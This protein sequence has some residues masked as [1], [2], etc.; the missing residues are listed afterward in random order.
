MLKLIWLKEIKDLLRDRK[1]LWFVLLMPTLIMP[2][3]MGGALYLT[4]SGI[5]DKQNETLDFQLVAPPAWRDTLGTLL[6]GHEGLRWQ[7]ELSLE[8]EAQWREAIE[9]ERLHFVLQVP[10]GFDPDQ[11]HPSQWQLYYNQ[12]EDFGQ[13]DRIHKALS[14]LYEQWREEHRQR[15]GLTESQSQML[16]E[17]VSLTMVGTA[18]EREAIGERIG[19][20]LPYLLL[21]L[22]LIGAMMPALDVAAG[23]KERGTLETL[24]MAPVPRWQLVL[25]KFAVIGC[26]SMLVATLS[27]LCGV[28]WLLLAGQVFAVSFLVTAATTLGAFD[29]FLI[30]LLILPIAFAMSAMLLALSVYARSYKEAQNYMSPVS[31]LIFLPAM[32]GMVPGM[33]LKGGWLWAPIVNVTLAI[34]ELIKGT[35]DYS[36]LWP[37]FTANAL[38]A[39]ILL[40]FCTFWFSRERVLFR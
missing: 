7:R 1:T 32:V 9:A 2:A 23:E 34:K 5:L 21:A 24:L 33:E 17:P 25:A 31:F 11:D 27:L 35:I 30:L 13:Y 37:V 4:S 18:D 3:L 12:T 40:A 20:L 39:L 8:G 26:A 14:P 36:L 22:C 38:L 16:T 6:D 28:I 15:W 19:G 10:D 29:I